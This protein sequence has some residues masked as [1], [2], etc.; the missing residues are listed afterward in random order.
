MGTSNPALTD[1]DASTISTIPIGDQNSTARNA[2]NNDNSSGSNQLSVGRFNEPKSPDSEYDEELAFPDS[3]TIVSM[4]GD[5]P[6]LVERKEGDTESIVPDTEIPFP[7]IYNPPVKFTSYQRKI[8]IPGVETQVAVIDNERNMTMHLLNPNL[9]TIQITHGP[10]IWTIK[11]RYK[12]F[13]TLHQ[14]LRMFRTSLNFPFPTRSHKERRASFRTNE[15]NTA[16]EK[17]PKSGKP[18][19]RKA[20]LPRFPKKPDALVP[21]EAVPTRMK[22]LEEYLYN[23]LN[24][25]LY[26]NHPDT[27]SFLEISNL[28]FV[29]ALGDKGKEGPVKKRTGSTR[30]G[31]SGCN[32]FGCFGLCSSGCCVRCN[33][34]CSDI[35]CGKWRNRWFFVKETCFGYL[36]PNDGSIRAV[37][38]FD[39]GF[40]VS[41][42]VY[43]SVT[44]SGLQVLTH[45]R[46]VVLKCWTRRKAREW[47]THLKTVANTTA[48]DFTT[49]NPHM[50]FAPVRSGINAGWFVDG[51]GYMSAVADAMENA[52]EEIYIADWWLSPEIYMKRPAIS[53]DY[54]RL[55]KILQRKAQQGVKVFV[56]LY[57]EVEMA[58]GINSYYSKQKLV[59]AH[60]NIKV[61]RHPDHARVGVFLWA[62]HEK[63]VAIDQTYAFL[64]GIDLCYGRWDDYR[65]RLTD[66]GSVTTTSFS[67]SGQIRSNSIS[68]GD[69]KS[70]GVKKLNFDTIDTASTAIPILEPGDK[71]LMMPASSTPEPCPENMK[72]NS[73]DLER[74][75][76]LEKLKTN[77]KTKSKHFM[78]KISYQENEEDEYDLKSPTQPNDPSRNLFF[79]PN[80]L[81]DSKKGAN[82]LSPLPYQNKFIETLDGQ[83]KLWFGKDYTNFILKDFSNLDAPYVDLVD[84]TTT[85]RMPWHDIAAVVT[86][87]SARDVSRHFIQRWNA[88]KLGKSR[89]NPTFPYLIPKSYQNI[90]FDETFLKHVTLQRVSCQVLRSVSSWSCGFIEPDLIEQSIHEAYVQTISNAQ[91]YVYIENQFF[92]SLEVGNPNV[93]NQIAETLIKRIL[94]AHREGTIFRVYVV[95][96]LLPGFEGDVGGNTGAA[97]RAITHWNYASISRGKSSILARLKANGIDNPSEYISFHGLRTTSLLDGHPITE[98]IYVHSKLLI[99]DDRYVICGSANINDRSLIG[100]RDSEIAVL[101]TDEGFEDG[102]MNGASYPCGLYAGKLRKFLFKEHLGLLDPDP[103]HPI[104][105][106]DPIADTFWNGQWRKTSTRNT[107]VYDEVFKCIPT[108]AVDSFA[109]MKKYQETPSLSKTDPQKAIAALDRAQ[110]Y[111]VDLPLLFLA[112]ENLAP[113]L[114]TKE[115]I[116]P[117]SLWT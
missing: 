15:A 49:Q 11:K 10:F 65:H 28:S 46:H 116:M 38:L 87:A 113:N 52:K 112:K 19:K 66:L 53:G 41:T 85:P 4:G 21:A 54:W 98:L 43:T 22:Q 36:R 100:K 37:I 89:E 107:Q 91:H 106:T 92:I 101:I 5:N 29:A 114:I 99:A 26:K 44:R 14:S 32:C 95:L 74:R 88:L 111:I 83:A 35:M 16:I 33:F 96:P 6:I 63:I 108:D 80:E 78:N 3:V 9:Y 27:I 31:Q 47:L 61:M 94:R 69:G 72:Q 79:S 93:R 109:T 67:A 2:N 42:G 50:S 82:Y 8:Y 70:R 51:A 71:L 48:R 105:V 7:H 55:D 117:T 73:P 76:M 103:E 60:D 34:L 56:L 12:H 68:F 104:D 30:P 86:G 58:M 45:S 39:Q 25:T 24:I 13:N 102:R 64:G 18:K 115:G 40:D 1:G 23:L 17:S 84:R 97:L 77:V 90:A 59:Q 62:H 57:K 75:S 81:A 110:G 20:A